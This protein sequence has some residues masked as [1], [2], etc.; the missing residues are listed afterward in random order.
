[1]IKLNLNREKIKRWSY[2]AITLLVILTAIV[3]IWLTYRFIASNI[4]DSLILDTTQ[5]ERQFL[6]LDLDKAKKV[7]DYFDGLPENQ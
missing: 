5:A 6:K 1:M 4:N 3:L 2:T 7:A